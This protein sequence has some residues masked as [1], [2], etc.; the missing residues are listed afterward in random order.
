MRWPRPRWCCRWCWCSPLPGQLCH[1]RLRLC[2][3]GQ[4]C[5]LRRAGRLGGAAGA[6]GV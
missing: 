5:Q 3:G 4:R 2:G 1:C 6:A